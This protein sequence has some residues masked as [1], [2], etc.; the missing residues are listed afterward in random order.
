MTTLRWC[1]LFGLVIGAVWAFKGWY[2]ALVALVGT[3]V[4]GGIGLA[5][6][7]NVINFKALLGS[8]DDE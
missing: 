4:G 3:V 6:S 1:L 5:I 8:S 7:R 2:G